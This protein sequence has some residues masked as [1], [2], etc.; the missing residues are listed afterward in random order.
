[1]DLFV[2]GKYQEAIDIWQ[3][4]LKDYPYNKKV[5]TAIENARERL[6]KTK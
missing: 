3:E 2:K 1:M 6:K 4:I 5:L